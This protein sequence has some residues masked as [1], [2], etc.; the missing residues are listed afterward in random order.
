MKQQNR[1]SKR[2]HNERLSN[3]QP[4]PNDQRRS[5]RSAK[6]SA[7]SSA[8]LWSALAAGL[9]GLVTVIVPN[10]THSGSS[11]SA[12]ST[13]TITKT[14]TKNSDRASG[15]SGKQSNRNDPALRAIGFR[16]QQKLD[17]H[18]T[19]HGREFGNISK[20]QYLALAQ[21]LRDAPL[22]NTVIET[23]QKDGTLSRFNRL[24]GAF[25]AFDRSLIIRTF[26]KPNDG[27]NYFWRAAKLTH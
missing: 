18:Y 7:K 24:S 22:S 4:V 9:I 20:A 19:K 12:R 16:S 13:T 23:T 6:S 27:E 5:T 25:M 2:S 8:K 3:D 26:F 15:E 1:R 14:N 11:S 17:D 10:L 21:D